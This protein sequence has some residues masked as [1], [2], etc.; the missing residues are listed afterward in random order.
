MNAFTQ[1]VG[2]I[3]N[4]PSITY[5]TDTSITLEDARLETKTSVSESIAAQL[6]SEEEVGS[7]N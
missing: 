6:L 5:P 2:I 7:D 3:G 4:T 1:F